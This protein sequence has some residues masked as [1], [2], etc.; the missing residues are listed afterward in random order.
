MTPLLFCPVHVRVFLGR[1]IHI[2][3]VLMR[4][5]DPLPSLG[6]LEETQERKQLSVEWPE[7]QPGHLVASVSSL[8]PVLLSNQLSLPRQVLLSVLSAVLL[9]L[10]LA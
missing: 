4:L 7:A 1:A 10:Q 6:S 2:Q 8:F 5:I 3:G 9:S